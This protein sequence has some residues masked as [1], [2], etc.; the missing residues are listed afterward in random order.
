MAAQAA[1]QQYA[2]NFPLREAVSKYS[3]VAT[4]AGGKGYLSVSNLPR[5]Y[6]QTLSGNYLIA[7]TYAD[8]SAVANMSHVP[9]AGARSRCYWD[10]LGGTITGSPTIGVNC[11]R[12]Y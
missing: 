10:Y 1:F 8:N 3:A 9:Y 6:V 2:L 12:A 4:V 7:S 5:I 11:W